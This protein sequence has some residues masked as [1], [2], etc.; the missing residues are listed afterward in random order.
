[1]SLHHGSGL[2]IRAK[3][4]PGLLGSKDLSTCGGNS[5]CLPAGVC[6]KGKC[7]I[8]QSPKMAE[9]HY[10]V[11]GPTETCLINTDCLPHGICIKKKC[12][13]VQD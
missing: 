2:W 11:L 13:V 7:Q 9:D 12:Q 1:M 5:D 4:E 10:S 6:I 8:L 3:N